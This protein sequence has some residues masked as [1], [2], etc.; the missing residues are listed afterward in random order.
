MPEKNDCSCKREF[1]ELRILSENI[2][3]GVKYSL[4]SKLKEEKNKIYCT[5]QGCDFNIN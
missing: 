4:P 3:V 2:L 5:W 1:V